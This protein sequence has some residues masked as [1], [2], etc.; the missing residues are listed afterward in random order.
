[1]TTFQS[2][3]INIYGEKGKIWFDELRQLVELT[4]SRLGLR[5]LKNATN[6]SYNYML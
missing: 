6:L 4:S 2:H 3:I 5:D 1:M